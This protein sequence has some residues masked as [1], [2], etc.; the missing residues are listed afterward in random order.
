GKVGSV[1]RTSLRRDVAS[2]TALR[3]V[4]NKLH[5]TIFRIDQSFTPQTKNCI[6]I[7][8]C[9]RCG[10][11]YVGETKNTIRMR[12]WQHTYNIRNGKELHTPLVNHFMLHGLP[13][14]RVAGLQ[15][16]SWWSDTQRKSNERRWIYRL[17]TIAP[18][19]L[20]I[21]Y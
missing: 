20:N 19:G 8:F 5:N 14:L 2:F 4:K 6:Y 12:V 13:A 17:Q 11:Q 3:Y 21:K 16:Y 7:I 1:Q 9:F 15:S 18:N 10:K